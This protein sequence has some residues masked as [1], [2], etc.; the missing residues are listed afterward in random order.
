MV[1][2]PETREVPPHAALRAD[3]RLQPQVGAAARLALEQRG[4]GAAARAGLSPP[5]RRAAHGRARQPEGRRAHARRLRPGAEPALPRSARALRCHG[6]AVP[7]AASRS[8]GQ[9]RA[10]R[11]SRAARAARASLREPRGGPGLP[12]PLGGALG[13]HAHPRHDEAPG[14]G[15]VRRGEAESSAAAR[16]AV[17]LLPPR[18]ADR[19]PRR[20]RRGRGRL[21]PPA[22]GLARAPRGGAVG[23][24]PRADPRPRA[25]AALVREHVRQERGRRRMRD[26]DR[27]DADAGD[28]AHAARAGR[29]RGEERRCP[30]P[31]PPSPR[32]RGRR[33]P[34]PRRAGAGQEARRGGDRSGLRRGPRARRAE[35][36]LREALPRAPTRD[37]PR[38]HADRSP[39]PPAHALPRR[40]RP[41]HH[42]KEGDRP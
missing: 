35:L 2:D 29:A 12:R 16:R 40:H 22:A 33:A 5:R 42:P 15:D 14:G 23:R 27:P 26:E 7:A 41:P 11:R 17:S 32:G 8:Q 13:R 3:A 25:P 38:P 36:R 37:G 4:L 39:D 19:A 34:H 30:V 28:D 9:S 21:L 10:R 18:H 31:A 1:R 24:A 20:R 6:A